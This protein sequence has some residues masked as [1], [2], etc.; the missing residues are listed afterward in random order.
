MTY[1]GQIPTS[2]VPSFPALWSI[3]NDVG[4]FTG[5][6]QKA[7]EAALRA[8]PA[9]GGD[10]WV[11]GDFVFTNAVEVSKP[12]RFHL[13]AGTTIRV[14]HT[15][16]VGAFS[17]TSGAVGCGLLGPGLIF[18]TAKT[19]NQV[20]VQFDSCPRPQI[21][22]G[23]VIDD[24]DDAGA[25]S[26]PA[27][28]LYMI[29]TWQPIVDG[30]VIH[31]N[32]GSYGFHYSSRRYGG[33]FRNIYIGTDSVLSF[34]ATEKPVSR[35]T[36]GG[37]L[38]EGGGYDVI[39]NVRFWGLGDPA[40]TDPPS[41]FVPYVLKFQLKLSGSPIVENGHKNISN[42]SV[43]YCSS[44][45]P[46]QCFG[47]TSAVWQGLRVGYM[48][49]SLTAAGHAVVKIT[50]PLGTPTGLK[51]LG[52]AGLVFIGFDLHNCWGG[53][54]AAGFYINDCNS[55]K[56][57]GGS[58][59]LINNAGLPIVARA[60]GVTGPNPNNNLWNVQISGCTAVANTS[61]GTPAAFYTSDAHIDGVAVCGNGYKGFA[62]FSDV[63]S[64]TVEAG[65]YV[66]TDNYAL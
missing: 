33:T 59:N 34:A 4:D 13:A 5:R 9:R 12:V 58:F 54:D 28:C 66:E 22:G 14:Q 18:T 25:S 20:L 63:A 50:G 31:P 29:D 37:W 2:S 53:A 24:Q 10:V 56:L 61:S 62:A 30:L 60:D 49:D 15:G 64:Q 11:D 35:M 65:N 17:F 48:R 23:L 57:Q 47:L 51:D 8:M 40:T 43:E 32:A 21:G 38:F 39:D 52:S 42:V 16:A 45:N 55:T 7:F 27:K 44:T 6:S 1:L 46:I 41:L 3:S 19:D 26:N 36:V